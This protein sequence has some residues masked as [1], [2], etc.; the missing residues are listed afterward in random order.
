LE[1]L[2]V[3]LVIVM[4]VVVLFQIMGF[5]QRFGKSVIFLKM[6]AIYMFFA[7]IVIGIAAYYF[8]VFIPESYLFPFVL[9]FIGI[10]RLV[11]AKNL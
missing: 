1:T 3:F 5:S 9:V 2:K 7:A 11:L 10:Y 4:A 6:T 8:N